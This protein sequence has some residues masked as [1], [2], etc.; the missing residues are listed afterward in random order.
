MMSLWSSRSLYPTIPSISTACLTGISTITNVPIL[1]FKTCYPQCYSY[2][3][4][5]TAPFQFLRPN[6]CG[7]LVS[8]YTFFGIFHMLSVNESCS[9]YLQTMPRT[10]PLLIYQQL[11]PDPR[12]T[13]S[14]DTVSREFL[15]K[16]GIFPSMSVHLTQSES[17]SSYTDF[18]S[19]ILSFWPTLA[20]LSNTLLQLTLTQP[21]WPPCHCRT[22]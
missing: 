4:I 10:W 21:H 13:S 11:S 20:L 16:D 17:Q 9:L 2:F 3:S 7:I 15:S 5:Q 6:D 18:Q 8:M 19:L 12:T 22:H 1:P 14:F